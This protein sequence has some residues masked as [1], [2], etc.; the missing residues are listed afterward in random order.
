MPS[1]YFCNSISHC[2]AGTTI[3]DK[4]TANKAARHQHHENGDNIDLK[5][6]VWQQILSTTQLSFTILYQHMA[7][8]SNIDRK[9]EQHTI[10]YKRKGYIFKCLQMNEN[11]GH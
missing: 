3:Y 8:D 9:F 7:F 5:Y 1:L 2:L 4:L 6:N 11:V 10:N